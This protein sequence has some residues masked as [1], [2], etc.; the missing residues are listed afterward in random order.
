MYS[1]IS[2]MLEP[3]AKLLAVELESTVKYVELEPKPKLLQ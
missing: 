2:I 1:K 3:K